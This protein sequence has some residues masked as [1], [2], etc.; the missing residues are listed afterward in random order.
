V[1]EFVCK[2]CGER[3]NIPDRFAGRPYK[4]TKCGIDGVVPEMYNK[5]KF[6]CMNCGQHLRVPKTYAGKEAKCPKCK[7]TL[8]VP[9]FKP[10]E[11]DP[12]SETVTVICPMC[13]E[14]LHPTK[15]SKGQMMACPKC[16]SYIET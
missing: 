14:V 8:V 3:L 1:I 6:H 13:N 9:P 15:A 2:L 4:C 16:D 7:H 5:I 12:G 10:P 11:P